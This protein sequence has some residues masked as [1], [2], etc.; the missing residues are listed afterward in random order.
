MLSAKRRGFVSDSARDLHQIQQALNQ[1]GI[2]YSI[3]QRDIRPHGGARMRWGGNRDAAIGYRI[4]A[5]K[6]DEALARHMIG[7]CCVGKGTQ[8]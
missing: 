3:R 5:D 7:R 4:L 2:D 1:A 8:Q 6:K